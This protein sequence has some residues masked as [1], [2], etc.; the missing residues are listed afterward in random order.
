M[1]KKTIEEL[2]SMEPKDRIR[3]PSNDKFYD[4]ACGILIA[5][6]AK[7][8]ERDGW[9]DI[10]TV[11]DTIKEMKAL[12]AKEIVKDCYICGEQFGINE[13]NVVEFEGDHL[14]YSCNSCEDVEEN[15]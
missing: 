3:E 15:I 2:F 9:M 10:L 4:E 7:L 13:L 6:K 8:E 1:S 5:F 14:A 11:G 12:C